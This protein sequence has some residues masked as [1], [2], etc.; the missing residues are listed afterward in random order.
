MSAT[1]RL[2]T[3]AL[4]TVLVGAA[5]GLLTTPANRAS[6]SCY[7]PY[8]PY[9]FW[10]VGQPYIADAHG[11]YA[12]RDLNFNFGPWYGSSDWN[13]TT[14]IYPVRYWVSFG[15][16]NCGWQY[17]GWGLTIQGT[18]QP[19]GDNQYF[20]TSWAG[21]YANYNTSF[22]ATV[23]PTWHFASSSFGVTMGMCSVAE[24]CHAPQLMNVFPYPVPFAAVLRAWV[25]VWATT[26]SQVHRQFP[27][28]WY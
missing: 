17:N 20:V 8:H 5:A 26:G 3:L 16:P 19:P 24:Q 25:P 1:P 15:C 10:W 11:Q 14:S 13:A 23:I 18:G 4:A 28:A 2:A 22:S 7:D 21:W 6:A 27:E 12:Y 9:C